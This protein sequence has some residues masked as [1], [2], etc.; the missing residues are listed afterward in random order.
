MDSTKKIDYSKSEAAMRIL[1]T[2]KRLF[3][4]EGI[5]SVGID[6]IVKESNVA[7]NTMYKY[8]PSKDTLVEVY[9]TERDK[10]WMSWLENS[11]AQVK[12]PREKLLAIFDALDNWFHEDVFRGCAFIN[13][14][15]EV[16]TT[17]S[18]IHNISKYHKEKLYELILKIAEDAMIVNK[19][20]VAKEFLIL[21]EGAIVVASISEN[22]DAGKT[23]KKNGR[24]DTK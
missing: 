4:S 10:Y 13:A 6:R 5:Q 15:G 11:V 24:A 19:E 12:E 16:G 17:K 8:F 20:Q 23:A 18:Y 7:M 1:D 2:A 21:I 14:Y 9:L 22:K 3:Y